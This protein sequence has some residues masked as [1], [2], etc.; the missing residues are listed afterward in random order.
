MEEQKQSYQLLQAE[1]EEAWKTETANKSSVIQLAQKELEERRKKLETE[2]SAH[3]R[4]LA[5]DWK[6]LEQQEQETLA[7]LQSKEKDLQ[8]RRELLDWEI[9]QEMEQVIKLRQTVLTYKLH[10]AFQF[11]LTFY[12][13]F[14][15]FLNSACFI[16]DGMDSF[17]VCRALVV[18][19]YFWMNNRLK[20]KLKK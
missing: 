14:V 4:R 2:Y 9:D 12:F 13:F 17:C 7:S 15:F 11:F 3:R 18:F 6:R 5:E 1:K 10:Y 20:L 19:I 8:K 16:N